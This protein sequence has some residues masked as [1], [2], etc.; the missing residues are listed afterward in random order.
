MPLLEVGRIG[1]AH[2]LKG[3]VVID[4]VTDRVDERTAIGAELTSGERRFV[5]ASARPH[6]QKWLV[7]FEGVA[8]RNAAEAL[9]GLVLQAEALEDPDVVFVHEVIGK[10]LVDQHGNDHGPVVSVIENPASD[11]MELE[12]GRL[13]PL[14]FY[15]HNDDR[16]VT[17]SVPPGLLDDTD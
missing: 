7:R 16:V 13:V 12:D 4:F 2:G 15:Q 9:R 11:L 6:Q 1:K 8:D 14:A 3:E 10:R 5:V 17:V